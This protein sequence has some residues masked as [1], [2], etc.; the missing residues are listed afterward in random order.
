MQ[1][2]TTEKLGPKRSLTPQGYLLCKDVPIAR[3]GEQIYLEQEIGPGENGERVRGATDGTIIVTRDEKD[4]FTQEAIDSFEGMPITDEHPDE[5]VT[6][7]NWQDLAVG[8]VRNVRR[9]VGETAGCLVADLMVCAKRAIDA[10]E[11]G[12]REIS[13][14]YNAVYDQIMPGR[15]RQLNIRGNHVAFVEQGR[16]GPLC[17]ISDHQATKDIK[18]N[19]MAN[20]K[21]TWAERARRAFRS[22]DE[23][24]FEDAI[25]MAP[26]TDALHGGQ[27]HGQV[28]VHVNGAVVD[29]RMKDEDGEKKEDK[30]EKADKVEDKA[31][32]PVLDKLTSI[33]A[34][35]GPLESFMRDSLKT[36]DADG[37]EKKEDKED[38]TKKPETKDWDEEEEKK[39]KEDKKDTKDSRPRTLINTRAEWQDTLARGEILMPGIR[40]PTFDA[41]IDAKTVDARLCSFRR[42]VISAA[43]ETDHGNAAIKPY[44]GG[45]SIASL[46]C[47]AMKVLFAAASDNAKKANMTRRGMTAV[48]A[49]RG[50]PKTNDEINKINREYY[51]KR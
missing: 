47:D 14:G 30:E 15:A 38:E 7:N 50:L 21:L 34:R 26:E 12:K 49:G 19:I 10:I 13:C 9:G 23:E 44:L 29:K 11:Q 16:C 2:Y 33:E 43:Y 35:L 18:D 17:A 22:K 1:I 28:H 3:T 24:L 46:T 51:A 42:R 25:G 39:D 40:L 45:S 27:G 4:V 6:P 5:S 8:Y 32:K 37:E 36:K 48:H 20:A 41:A 31:L